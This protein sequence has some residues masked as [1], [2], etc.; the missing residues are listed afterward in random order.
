MGN[1]KDNG[2]LKVQAKQNAMETQTNQTKSIQAGCSTNKAR[3]HGSGG[4]W[5]GGA[6][7]AAQGGRRPRTGRGAY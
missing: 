5:R 3:A 7:P 6:A 1:A 2:N 4:W